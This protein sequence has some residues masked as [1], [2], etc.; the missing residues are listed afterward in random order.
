M[1]VARGAKKLLRM[2]E[3]TPW[4]TAS[5]S[6]LRKGCFPGAYPALHVD[7]AL[8][9]REFPNGPC[10]YLRGKL[11]GF[12]ASLEVLPSLLLRIATCTES[13]PYGENTAMPEPWGL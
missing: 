6:L 10:R 8:A 7:G 5:E 9:T 2:G 3:P 12:G 13:E 1:H 4:R 11:C